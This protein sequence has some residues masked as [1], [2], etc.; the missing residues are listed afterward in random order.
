MARGMYWHNVG[1][2]TRGGRFARETHRWQFGGMHDAYRR[3]SEDFEAVA[4]MAPDW[5]A[6]HAMLVNI[7]MAEGE[8]DASE[9]AFR[10]GVAADPTDAWPYRFRLHAAS[11]WWSARNRAEEAR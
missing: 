3:A 5:A 6:P 8:N 2:A 11:P 9:A 7:H 1:W 10:A 4:A